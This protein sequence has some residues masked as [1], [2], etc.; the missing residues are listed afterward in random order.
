MTSESCFLTHESVRSQTIEDKFHI[1]SH[2]CIILYFFSFSVSWIACLNASSSNHKGNWR[3]LVFSSV[4]FS[5]ECK[6]LL[7]P[8][9]KKFRQRRIW[10]AINTIISYAKLFRNEIIQLVMMS[11]YNIASLRDRV[12]PQGVYGDRKI[13]IVHPFPVSFLC[14]DQ[15]EA[16]ISSRGQTPG[17]LSF[18]TSV[19]TSHCSNIKNRQDRKVKY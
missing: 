16:S 11:L 6:Y 7:Y 3:H 13:S 1:Y 12:R 17:H 10:Q 9:W 2:L 5:S 18:L 19:Y 15:I 14:V 4:H 8:F